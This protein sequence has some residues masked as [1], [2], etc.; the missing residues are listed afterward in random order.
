MKAKPH[1]RA[2]ALI[3]RFNGKVMPFANLPQPAQLSI[4]HYM[5]LDG[6]AWEPSDRFDERALR[7]PGNAGRKRDLHFKRN[8]IADLPHFVETYG[9]ERFGLVQIPMSALTEAIWLD[10]KEIREDFKSFAE[11]HKWY[12]NAGHMPQHGNSRWPV[13]LSDFQ[14]EESTLQDG[15]HRFH[16]YYRNNVKIVPAVYFPI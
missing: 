4:A 7:A 1:V 2:Q 5:A 6:E 13:I 10:S 8:L 3:R 9:K 11:Y 12:V 14:S 16:D 15:W